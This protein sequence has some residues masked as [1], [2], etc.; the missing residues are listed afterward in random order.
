MQ[1]TGSNE[2]WSVSRPVT[3]VNNDFHRDEAMSPCEQSP[4]VA[5]AAP[6]RNYDVRVHCEIAQAVRA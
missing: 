4:N 1:T 3:I 6:R 2:K 5:Y